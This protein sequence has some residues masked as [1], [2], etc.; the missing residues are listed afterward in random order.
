MWDIP[1][2]RRI[3]GRQLEELQKHTWH[4]CE[5]FG[6]DRKIENFVRN[7]IFS[8]GRTLVQSFFL[9]QLKTVRTIDL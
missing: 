6:L 7:Q 8:T 5:A 1:I 2:K 3:S 4:M 9:P